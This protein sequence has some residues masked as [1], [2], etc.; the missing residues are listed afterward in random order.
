[1]K[2]ILLSVVAL[3]L[4]SP[5][6]LRAGDWEEVKMSSVWGSMAADI[7]R[8]RVQMH[9]AYDDLR[10]D[11]V[12]VFPSLNKELPPITP[13]WFSAT[14]ERFRALHAK[15][16]EVADKALAVRVE[17]LEKRGLTHAQAV[18]RAE[19][20]QNEAFQAAPPL[21]PTAAELARAKAQAKHEAKMEK[22]DAYE[23]A[24]Q[25][26]LLQEIADKLGR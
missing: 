24:E 21:P 4:L 1:M 11:V 10:A 13:C 15:A 19:D 7:Q 8:Q 17:E 5:A 23:R 14:W 3:V 20:E 2:T 9:A 22:Q 6:L 25:R 16:V 18:L 26:R 12:F